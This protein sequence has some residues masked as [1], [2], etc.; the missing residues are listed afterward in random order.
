MD[1]LGRAGPERTNV[2]LR[3]F[4]GSFGARVRSG[5]PGFEFRAPGGSLATAGAASFRVDARAGRELVVSVSEGEVLT[6][7]A[8]ERMTVRI[9]RAHPLRRSGR[10]WTFQVSAGEC[11]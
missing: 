11:G 5:G 7:F 6:D 8:G 1:S 9:G 3:V 2:G 4:A 10:G